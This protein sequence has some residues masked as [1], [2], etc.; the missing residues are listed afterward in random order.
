MII[1]LV[2][3]SIICILFYIGYDYKRKLFTWYWTKWWAKQVFYVIKSF[4]IYVITGAKLVLR[5]VGLY[6]G[7]V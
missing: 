3:L 7:D 1:T 4:G 5:W 6:K 2:L